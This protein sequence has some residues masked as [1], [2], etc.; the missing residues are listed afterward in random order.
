MSG[1]KKLGRP[2]LDDRKKICLAINSDLI[3]GLNELHRKTRVPKSR[4]MDSALALLLSSHS[5]R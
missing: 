4:L 5:G 2:K 3:K 1:E